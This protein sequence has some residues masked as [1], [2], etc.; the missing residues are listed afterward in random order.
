RPADAT[1]ARHRRRPGRRAAPVPRRAQRR[2]RAGADRADRPRRQRGRRPVRAAVLVAV[3]VSLLVA[4]TGPGLGRRLPPAAAT[5]LLVAAGVLVAGCG[6]FVLGVTAF[7]WIG[8][9]PPIA[10]ARQWSAADLRPADPIP[11]AAA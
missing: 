3:A 6:V 8:Q 7:T 10:A 4:A 9:L 11:P 1:P 2:R 5:R